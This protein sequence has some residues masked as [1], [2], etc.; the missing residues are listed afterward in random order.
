MPVQKQSKTD[1]VRKQWTR[2]RTGEPAHAPEAA[3]RGNHFAKPSPSAEILALPD[4]SRDEGG[5]DVPALPPTQ[6]TVPQGQQPPRRV[7]APAPGTPVQDVPQ[8]S[9]RH[10]KIT[11]ASGEMPALPLKL[12]HAAARPYSR[13][14]KRY[15]HHPEKASMA[16]AFAAFENAPRGGAPAYGWMPFAVYG[17]AGAVVTLAWCAA[18]KLT[19]T[20]VP[21][22]GSLEMVIGLALLCAVVVAGIVLVAVTT[23]MTRRNNDDLATVDVLASALGKAALMM[24]A[25]A[26]V[27]VLAMAAVTGFG[28]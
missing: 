4:P 12:K 24:L 14:N 2:Q 1:S 3:P 7:Q 21:G 17:L 23:S 26:V 22:S 27:W 8:A 18:V 9:Q 11:G 28:A 15:V 16:A 6:S 20:G 5:S 13:Y 19:T 25:D 10:V